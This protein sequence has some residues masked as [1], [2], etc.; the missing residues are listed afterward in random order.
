MTSVSARPCLCAAVRAKTDV[1]Q[2]IATGAMS[3]I[4]ACYLWLT[5]ASSPADL[6]L[7][8]AIVPAYCG[9]GS[10]PK[11]RVGGRGVLWCVKSG[12]KALQN[13]TRLGGLFSSSLV[14][15]L[16]FFFL[17]PLSFSALPLLFL[18]HLLRLLIILLVL[19]LLPLLFL[20]F[21]YLCLLGLRFLYLACLFF[22]ASFSCISS[23]FSHSLF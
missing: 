8:S 22:Y 7:H 16:S 19:F 17:S 23:C 18:L 10:R 3:L 4:P 1:E 15:F 20:L 13:K 2:I 14:L 11:P 12:A 6:R 9:C 5:S 21:L